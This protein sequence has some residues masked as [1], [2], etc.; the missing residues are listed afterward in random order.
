MFGK[1]EIR[2]EIPV[3]LYCNVP[4]QMA[5]KLLNLNLNFKAMTRVTRVISKGLVFYNLF[6]LFLS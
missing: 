4:E 2:T 3:Y 6:T 5:N 1:P